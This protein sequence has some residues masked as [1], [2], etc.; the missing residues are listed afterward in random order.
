M[1]KVGDIVEVTWRAC[2]EK[3]DADDWELPYYVKPVEPRSDSAGSGW[4]PSL[5]VR[6]AE[7]RP[8]EDTP[9]TIRQDNV[10]G[11][12]YVKSVYAWHLLTPE[13]PD[14]QIR[15]SDFEMQNS[16]VVD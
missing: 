15:R 14:S 9:G 13:N 12:R 11:A 16:V 5:F 7:T 4:F 2:V 8:A 1:F 3:V 10:S 6:K